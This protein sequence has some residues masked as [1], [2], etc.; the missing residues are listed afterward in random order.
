MIMKGNF[1]VNRMIPSNPFHDYPLP[2]YSRLNLVKKM[3]SGSTLKSHKTKTKAE[4]ENTARQKLD[5]VLYYHN[6]QQYSRYLN[7]WRRKYTSKSAIF[8][9]FTGLWPWP[10]M[11]LR[12]I[13]LRMTCR[14]LPIPSIHLWLHW[15]WLWMGGWT[16]IFSLIVW[17]ISAD[18]QRSLK[19]KI[20]QDADPI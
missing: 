6:N 10:R 18:E 15:V 8:A 3:H 19:V 20:D 12:I 17:V 5:I 7:K 14:P 1:V 9:T 2:I 13:S 11:T 16:D 4:V